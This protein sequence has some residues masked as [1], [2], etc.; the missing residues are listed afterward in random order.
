MCPVEARAARRTA[1][2][3]VTPP[4]EVGGIAALELNLT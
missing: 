1:R 3:A 4:P 2:T